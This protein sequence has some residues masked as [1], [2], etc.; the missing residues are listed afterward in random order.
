[1]LP[2]SFNSGKTEKP[3]RNRSLQAAAEL[4]KRRQ[5]GDELGDKF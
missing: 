4:R 1:M 2:Y 5:G 3:S